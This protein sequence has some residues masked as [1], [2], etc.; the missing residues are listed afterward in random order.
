V[1]LPDHSQRQGPFTVEHLINAIW[2]PDV[3]HEVLHRKVALFHGELDGF[4]RVGQLE[5]KVFGFVRL[6]QRD[7]YV[8]LVAV[9]RVT[10]CLLVACDIEDGAVILQDARAADIAF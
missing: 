5:W 6:D 8:E 9:G 4:D 7:Q 3:G 10:L 1:Q 2:L